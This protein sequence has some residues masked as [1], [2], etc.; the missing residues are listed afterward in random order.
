MFLGKVLKKARKDKG[1]TQTELAQGICTQNTISKAENHNVLPTAKIL[2][3]LCLRLNLTPNDLFSEFNY[4]G[5]D[6]TALLQGIEK[7]LYGNH[8][9]K[10]E[11]EKLKIINADDISD[12]EKA[13]YY[14]DTAYLEYENGQFEDCLFELDK[15]LAMTSNDNY[16]IY[17]LL[18][19]TLKGQVY[20][21]MSQPEKAQYFFDLVA[22]FTVEN[23]QIPKSISGQ[24]IFICDTLS[25]F[26]LSTSNFNQSL[27]YAKRGLQLNQENN[28]A[29][30]LDNLFKTAYLTLRGL[31]KPKEEVNKYQ[32][33]YKLFEAYKKTFL[34]R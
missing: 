18:A 20:A 5:T 31:N 2:I 15:V 11:Q 22:G 28:S 17:S 19:Y 16:S 32:R 23:M 14:Y 26:Y 21:T 9:V 8:T 3:Q 27:K 6:V 4:A 1:I 34:D 12:S 33:F 10:D 7:R 29:Y 25:S 13:L 24:L 30:F